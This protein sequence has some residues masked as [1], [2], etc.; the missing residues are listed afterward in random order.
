MEQ[1]IWNHHSKILTTVGY[2]SRT[3]MEHPNGLGKD[4]TKLDRTSKTQPNP[5]RSYGKLLKLPRTGPNM[6]QPIK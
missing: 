1:L 6:N 5:Q 2:D 4:L 3:R